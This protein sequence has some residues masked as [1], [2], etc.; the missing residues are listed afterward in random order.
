MLK[1]LLFS[2]LLGISLTIVLVGSIRLSSAASSSVLIAAVYYDTYLPNEPDESFRLTN[3][4]AGAVDLGNWTVTDGEGTITLTGNISPNASLWIANT[5]VSFTLEFGFS[6]AY[7]YGVDSDPAAPNLAR[8]GSVALGNNGD[9]LILKDSGGAIVD[10]IVWESGNA[11][12]TGWS[13]SSINPY[14]QGFFGIE[15]QILYR[16]LDQATGLPVSDTDT[17]HD[18]AQATDD[19]ING[20]KIRLM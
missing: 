13:G 3:I 17:F 7:E 15:G 6:P 14:D 10:S 18:W 5:A 2:L 16:K 12:G 19:D 8:S 11:A 20:K 4:S 1:R 9:E